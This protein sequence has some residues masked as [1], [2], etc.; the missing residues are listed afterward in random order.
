MCVFLHLFLQKP[1]EVPISPF[2][3][4]EPFSSELWFYILV[5]TVLVGLMMSLCNK[6]S[7]NDYHGEFVHF[8]DASLKKE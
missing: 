2:R 6:L 1:E 4:L 3:F 5:T 8:V 7:P